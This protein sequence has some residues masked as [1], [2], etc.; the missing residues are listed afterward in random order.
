MG[1]EHEQS[2]PA[3]KY[4]VGQESTSKGRVVRWSL[5]TPGQAEA[6]RRLKLYDSQ[7]RQEPMPARVKSPVTW[8]IARREHC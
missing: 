2:L 7:P 5:K 8:D 3:G 6:R 1:D 4:M